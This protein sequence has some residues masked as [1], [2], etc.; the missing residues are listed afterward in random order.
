[1]DTTEVLQKYVE[2]IETQQ[3]QYIANLISD[4]TVDNRFGLDPT[5]RYPLRASTP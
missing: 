3:G 5:H 1:M 2:E 4:S